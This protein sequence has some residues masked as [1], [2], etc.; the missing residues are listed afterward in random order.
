MTAGI[1]LIDPKTRR[2][3]ARP[4]LHRGWS[5]SLNGAHFFPSKEA[6]EA[7]ASTAEKPL[8]VVYVTLTEEPLDEYLEPPTG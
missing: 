7:F 2:F 8:T 6:A 3:A 1:L 4:G 5:L